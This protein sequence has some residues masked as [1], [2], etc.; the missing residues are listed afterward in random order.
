[1]KSETNNSPF[2]RELHFIEQNPRLGKALS[3]VEAVENILLVGNISYGSIPE[4]IMFPPVIAGGAP[5][6][7]LHGREPKDFDIFWPVFKPWL[8]GAVAHISAMLS[9]RAPVPWNAP[10]PNINREYALNGYLRPE[11]LGVLNFEEIGVDLVFFD[12]AYG[13]TPEEIVSTFDTSI[14]RTWLELNKRRTAMI[15]RG[16]Q[17]FWRSIDQKRIWTYPN[18]PT[19]ASHLHRVVTKFP[20]YEL[21][22]NDPRLREDYQSYLDHMHRV[23][24][25]E[26]K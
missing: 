11:M 6:D 14:S 9:D 13:Q 21:T 3:I 24:P 4:G 5:R 16:A 20:G 26:A 19:R 12:A 18:V 23:P 1:M 8:V 2:I 25:V 17:D 22:I 15:V 10:W 7:M